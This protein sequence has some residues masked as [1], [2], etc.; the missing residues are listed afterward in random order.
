MRFAGSVLKSLSRG[1]GLAAMALVL[2]GCVESQRPLLEGAQ[3]LYGDWSVFSHQRLANGRVASPKQEMALIRWTGQRYALVSE[4]QGRVREL[5]IHPLDADTALIQ[6]VE[7]GGFF[8]SATFVYAVARKQMDGVWAV[9]PVDPAAAPQIRARACAAGREGRCR[10][11][12]RAD[13]I[14]LARATAA[15]VGSAD[16]LLVFWET[17]P[18]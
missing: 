10:I 2:A 8:G 1:V 15:T 11:D 9:I 12:S 16:G 18:I 6:G 13:L 3:P 4:S 5:T 7:G 14:A 17:D